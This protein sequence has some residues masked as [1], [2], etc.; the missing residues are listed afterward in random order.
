VLELIN[1]G[2]GTDDA[3]L[4]LIVEELP[5]RELR[6]LFISSRGRYE[7]GRQLLTQLRSRYDSTNPVARTRPLYNFDEGPAGGAFRQAN[8]VYNNVGICYKTA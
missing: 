4:R 3:R 7:Q 6:V 2:S 1:S 8:A 5:N